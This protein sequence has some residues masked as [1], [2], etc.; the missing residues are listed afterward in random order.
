MH[1][2]KDAIVDAVGAFILYPGEKDVF[3]RFHGAQYGF[4]GVG[5]I[6]LIPDEQNGE[7]QKVTLKQFILEFIEQIDV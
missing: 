1:T 5:G 7:A 3:Y 2:Y 4:E 6:S